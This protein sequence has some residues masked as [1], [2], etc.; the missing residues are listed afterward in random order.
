MAT[1]DT[2]TLA[3]QLKKLT[4]DELI[5]LIIYKNVA[6]VT[7]LSEQTLE[8]LDFV[9]NG[10][11]REVNTDSDNHGSELQITKQRLAFFEKE[12]EV[13]KRMNLHFEDRIGEQKSFIRLLEQNLNSQN[14]NN[15]NVKTVNN[16]NKNVQKATPI[17]SGNKTVKMKS[18]QDKTACTTVVSESNDGDSKADMSDS[19]RAPINRSRNN[20]RDVVHG[21]APTPTVAVGSNQD[22]FA[23]V[24]RRAYL[25]IGNINPNTSK[26]SVASYI[27]QKQP[28]CSYVLDELPRRDNA[29][30]RAFKLTI[31]FTMLETFNKPDVWP[32]GVIVKRFFRLRK[33]Q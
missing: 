22:S 26:D 14:S 4:K 9:L 13:L 15:R 6:Q 30:S 1:V 19:K 7:V 3:A 32:Q 21:V 20:Q 25:Y 17:V 29:L 18:P 5:N 8:Q 28:N 33:S 24:A 27:K 10:G 11:Q 12:S 23:G 2:V 31:D 16:V